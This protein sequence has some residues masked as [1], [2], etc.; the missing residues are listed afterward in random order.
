MEYM[1]I[2]VRFEPIDIEVNE[3]EEFEKSYKKL[4]S[5]LNEQYGYE[6]LPDIRTSYIVDDAGF[7]INDK[8]NRVK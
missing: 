1:K 7:P 6:I 3:Y 8:N 4:R 5:I 2:I